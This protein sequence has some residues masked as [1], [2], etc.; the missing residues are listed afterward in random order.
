MPPRL[1]RKKAAA[2]EKKSKT[3]LGVKVASPKLSQSGPRHK[4]PAPK[5]E[6]AGKLKATS[7]G[8]Q[9][10]STQLDEQHAKL[11]RLLRKNEQQREQLTLTLLQQEDLANT[12]NKGKPGKRSKGDSGKGKVRT[13]VCGEY[14]RGGV[15][16]I[17]IVYSAAR[18]FP[19]LDFYLRRF[20]FNT[21]F[22]L[23]DINKFRSILDAPDELWS[24]IL[25]QL[26]AKA[27]VVLSMVARGSKNIVD[28]A[29]PS[30]GLWW[31]ISSAII[32]AHVL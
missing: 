8:L 1:S 13:C 27:L 6:V 21:H 30:L 5:K 17:C 4:R 19:I 15:T 20:T 24:K 31:E 16:C 2:K 32:C 23:Q 7:Q 10:R 14:A 26:P 11:L 28:N 12:T 22:A 18:A 9:E 29:A 3:S 25:L